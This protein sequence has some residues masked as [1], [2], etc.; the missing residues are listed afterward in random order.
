MNL[1]HYISMLTDFM[2]V[3]NYFAGQ[4]IS[5]HHPTMWGSQYE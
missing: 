1:D 3:E 4:E 2:F 5:Q